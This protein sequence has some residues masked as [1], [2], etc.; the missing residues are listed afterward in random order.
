MRTG[1]DREWEAHSGLNFDHHVAVFDLDWID[2]KFEVR[3]APDLSSLRII[4]PT[5][6]WANNFAAFDHTFAEWAAEV[7]ADVVQRGNCAVHVCDTNHFVSA[8]EFF[9]LVCRGEIGLGS[10]LDEGHKSV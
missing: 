5:V 4:L 9:D 7:Q 8:G 1:A 3:I 6:P 10:E 2:G